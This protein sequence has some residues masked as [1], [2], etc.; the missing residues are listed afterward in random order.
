ME[1]ITQ[2]IYLD[3]VTMLLNTIKSTKLPNKYK[4]LGL[5]L[6]DF[7]KYAD[8]RDREMLMFI[9][10]EESSLDT[11][12]RKKTKKRAQANKRAYF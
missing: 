3:K 2:K 10:E 12:L 5:S 1:K 8:K 11:Y 7:E 9:V 6:G 4:G